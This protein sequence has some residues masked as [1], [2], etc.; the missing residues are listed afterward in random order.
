MQA[1]QPVLPKL[2]AICEIEIAAVCWASSSHF[3][4]LNPGYRRASKNDL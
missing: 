3:G 4:A 2:I 1:L